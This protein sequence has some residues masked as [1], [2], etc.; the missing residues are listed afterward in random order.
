MHGV[1][2]IENS[3]ETV[4]SVLIFDPEGSSSELSECL[5]SHDWDVS[6]VKDKHFFDHLFQNQQFLVVIVFLPLLQQPSIGEFEQFASMNLATKWIAIVPSESWL[7]ENPN[8]LFSH[9]F[10][11]YH[12]QPLRYEQLLDTI[13]HAY[14]MAQ[15]QHK[16]LSQLSLA[17][18]ND[19]LIGKSAASVELKRTIAKIAKEDATVLLTGE[20]GTG[21]ELAARSIHNNS[22][23]NKGP[24]VVINCA[25][26]PETLFYSELFG[27]EKG[28]FTGADEK[29]IGRIEAAHG[30]T[31]FLDE[32]G[33][34]PLSLQ[35]N[36]LRFLELSQIERLGSVK[37]IDI[38]CRILLATHVDLKQ[39]V[40]DTSFREDLYHRINVLPLRIPSLRQRVEDIPLLA[41]YFLEQFCRD[42]QQ[43]AFSQSCL[44][45]M[46]QHS[47]PGNV[48][49]LMNR[50][51]RAIILSEGQ[52]ILAKHL[53]LKMDKQLDSLTLKDVRDKAEKEA[54]VNVL[55]TVSFN[56]SLA[57]KTLSISRT[58]LYRLLHKHHINH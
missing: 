27:H 3:A 35:V 22:E 2:L 46:K 53:D 14:G 47:W 7:D 15:L 31:L 41:N 58:S 12:R 56:H 29:K 20:S 54:I 13:G 1:R 36:L 57:A 21:K 33:D 9:V 40:K 43:K 34:L 50:V 45:A 24:F 39:A 38:D 16:Q 30:G 26:I 37:S 48:R 4:R 17:S 51:R 28:T 23:R 5:N 55:E 11:D 52:I 19:E 8:F 6:A 44:Y 49:E 42:R 18:S 32:I 10:Y 25:A